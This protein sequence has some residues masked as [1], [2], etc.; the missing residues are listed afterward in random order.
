MQS[1]S[2]NCVKMKFIGQSSVD[3]DVDVKWWGKHP[4]TRASQCAI[5]QIIKNKSN[6]FSTRGSLLKWHA[7]DAAVAVGCTTIQDHALS[8]MLPR[9][10]G[11][12]S[13]DQYRMKLHMNV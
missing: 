9:A 2:Y 3:V 8:F 5:S 6:Y 7:V 13:Q 1:L 10:R 4:K 12:T 11:Q